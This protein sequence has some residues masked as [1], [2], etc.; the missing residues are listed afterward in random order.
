ME[1][2]RK[3]T[4]EKI[5]IFNHRLRTNQPPRYKTLVILWGRRARKKLYHSIFSNEAAEK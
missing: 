3:V 5:P 1:E 4:L 2:N